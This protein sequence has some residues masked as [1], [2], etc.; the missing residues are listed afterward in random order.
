MWASKG[1]MESEN[2]EGHK[3]G[4]NAERTGLEQDITALHQYQRLQ[5][6]IFQLLQD[7]W[8]VL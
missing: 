7:E 8:E 6:P 2:E 5:A 1:W 4:D 3:T